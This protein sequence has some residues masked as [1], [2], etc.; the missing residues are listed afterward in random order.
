MAGANVELSASGGAQVAA[1][2]MAAQAAIDSMH[3]KSLEVS[4]NVKGGR[5]VAAMGKNLDNFADSA[6]RAGRAARGMASDQ[7]R[8]SA[9][10]RDSASAHDRAGASARDHANATDR[11]GQSQRSF[12]EWSDV[13]AKTMRG[14]GSD[15][16]KAADANR[17]F[18]SSADRAGKQAQSSAKG[19]AKTFNDMWNAADPS[20]AQSF[21]SGDWLKGSVFDTASKS[22]P[23]AS[24]GL[25]SVGSSSGDM[26]RD[27][28]RGA[29]ALGETS[30]ALGSMGMGAGRA[31]QGLAG[32][33][34][35][36]GVSTLAAG[37]LAAVAGGMGVAG[38]M[39]LIASSGPAMS[40]VRKGV[41]G[42]KDEFNDASAGMGAFKPNMVSTRQAIEGAAGALAGV[43]MKNMET[44]LQA[45]ASAANTLERG[46][47]A[48]EP[49]VG[50]SIKATAALFDAAV[51]G[52]ANAAPAIADFASAVE[53]SSPGIEKLVTGL[54]EGVSAI[55]GRT[56]QALGALG[57]SG[58]VTP[59][60][61][62]GLAGAA[63]GGMLGA[64]I[65][66][67]IM[68]GFGTLMGGLIGAG[69][70]GVGGAAAAGTFSGSEANT[71]PT[72]TGGQLPKADTIAFNPEMATP[73]GGGKGFIGPT[74]GG[75]ATFQPGMSFSE[76]NKTAD[77]KK[78]ATDSATSLPSGDPF[79]AAMGERGK[80]SAP[81]DRSESPERA[82]SAR[83][84]FGEGTGSMS[85][86]EASALSSSMQDVAT[87]STNA[88]G[89]MSGIGPA[90]SSSFNQAQAGAAGMQS[91]MQGVQQQAQAVPPAVAP[92]AAAAASA[93]APPPP[94]PPPPSKPATSAMQSAVQETVQATAPMAA[95]GGADIGAAMGSGVGTGATRT[96]TKTLTTVVQWMENIIE[97]GA[98]AI[99]AHSPATKFIPIGM[100]IPQGVTAGVQ[101]GAAG[102]VSSVSGMMNQ[103]L[104][105]AGAQLGTQAS[106]AGANAGQQYSQQLGQQGQQGMSDF[107]QQQQA[108][109][110]A[111]QKANQ[112]ADWMPGWMQKA[113]AISAGMQ[114]PQTEQ[115]KAAEK[116]QKTVAESQAKQEEYQ[117]SIEKMG[118][119]EDTNKR[120][121]E[122][123]DKHNLRAEGLESVRDINKERAKDL[124]SWGKDGEKVGESLPAGL[125]KGI[126]K[127]DKDAVEAAGKL[128]ENAI[129]ENK[130]KAGTNS[131]STLT[132]E[133]GVD[134]GAGLTGGLN[135]ASSV[136][137]GVASDR[138]L[139]VGYTW[140]QSMATGA[141]SVMQKSL[142]QAAS[143]P[144][145]DFSP[146]AKAWLGA[147]GLLGPAGGGASVWKSPA[148]T[149][150]GVGGAGGSAITVENKIYLDSQLLDTKMDTKISAALDALASLIS[151][152]RG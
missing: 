92:A 69:I 150:G 126:Y 8:A 39:G 78:A 140:G 145:V 99:G 111:S 36:A 10:A 77:S 34:I 120:L 19:T 56:M 67:M 63:T 70:G 66:T 16:D 3:G 109:Q 152:Q 121:G 88:Q 44:T 74:V 116:Q 11:A 89:A 26:A 2:C 151:L 129:E 104:A 98:A 123:F 134:V 81:P 94:P 12:A 52:V 38:A 62:G 9:S 108:A 49:A 54:S 95:S 133:V 50:P 4:V 6:D 60:A 58:M 117:K 103:T 17:D 76:Q 23:S 141:Q 27:L 41:A 149:M 33:G 15:T 127:G 13:V 110:Q 57:D 46:L 131:P 138:G 45:G 114:F 71:V 47:Q 90:A 5:D 51:M 43:G 61:V 73:G 75:E 48:I 132:H 55:G 125:M 83:A 42:V 144:Q 97:A 105:G 136:A 119:S 25:N 124:A 106:Q 68:P 100:A 93:A 85:S 146:Q 30:S 143:M 102:A 59:A 35:V 139:K 82:T 32:I 137:E 79:Q 112:R 24:K 113:S 115:Q 87:S 122:K 21:L 65:G 1:E 96:M 37:A 107:A 22:G 7:D 40:E 128:A 101:A 28:G 142:F 20:G 31:M 80:T 14:A 18:G 72:A 147:E 84:G 91:N 53:A 130:K 135:A 86:R 64:G 118:Y 29:D 148:V